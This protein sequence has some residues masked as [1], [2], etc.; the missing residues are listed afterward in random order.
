M[1]N[2]WI[3]CAGITTV[4]GLFL[5]TPLTLFNVLALIIT[6]ELCV[7]F[8]LQS[9][10]AILHSNI[11]RSVLIICERVELVSITANSAKQSN[12]VVSGCNVVY[13]LSGSVFQVCFDWKS[14]KLDDGTIFWKLIWSQVLL[15]Y[16]RGNRTPFCL[17]NGDKEM[18]KE[19]GHKDIHHP[20]PS[21]HLWVPTHTQTQDS[22][23]AS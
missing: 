18:R 4:C 20:P 14:T 22:N 7:M 17:V 23:P 21:P 3:S 5:I 2:D 8:A 13:K 12:S 9:A 6:N 10:E 19:R 11:N 15:Q 1:N 16:Q